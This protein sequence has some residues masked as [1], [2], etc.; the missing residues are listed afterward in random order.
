MAS[1]EELTS[2]SIISSSACPGA[3]LFG[4][5]NENNFSFKMIKQTRMIKVTL[6][7]YSTSDHMGAVSHNKVHVS[8]PGVGHN[9][10][11]LWR[12]T[13]VLDQHH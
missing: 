7:S 8:A 11:H 10:V 5:Q 3:D 4:G 9:D 12:Y 13:E 6:C 1:K 2:E